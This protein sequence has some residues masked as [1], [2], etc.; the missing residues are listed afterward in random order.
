MTDVMHVAVQECAAAWKLECEQ[1]LCRVEPCRAQCHAPWAKQRAGCGACGGG[2][3][4]VKSVLKLWRLSGSTC[5]GDGQCVSLIEL[6]SPASPL[7]RY[8]PPVRGVTSVT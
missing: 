7:G 4:R 5:V 6:T 2:R 3:E 8:F 1:A